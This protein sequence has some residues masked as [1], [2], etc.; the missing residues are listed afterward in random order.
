MHIG[1]DLVGTYGRIDAELGPHRLGDRRAGVHGKRP[2]EVRA[3]TARV[4]AVQPVAGQVPKN[5]RDSV[6]GV[7]GRV[8]GG[9][10][11]CAVLLTLA[12]TVTVWAIT[13]GG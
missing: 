13:K 2:P 3:R 9:I 8:V 6:D 12:V 10:C 5:A 4:S 11:I 1:R 7:G